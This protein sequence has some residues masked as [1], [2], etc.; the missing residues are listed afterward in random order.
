MDF[1]A[2][3]IK[4]ALRTMEQLI[5]VSG[6][7]L[8]FEYLKYVDYKNSNE[9]PKNDIGW[10]DGDRTVRFGG[11]DRHFWL[12]FTIEPKAFEEDREL[13]LSVTTGREGGWDLQNPQGLVYLNGEAY[14]ALDTN[15][16]W[17]SL[18]SEKKY[19]VYIYFYTGMNDADFAIYPRICLMDTQLFEL[20][21]DIKTAYESMHRQGGNRKIEDTLNKALMLLDFRNPYS[22]DFY[23]SIC[24]TREYLESEL[25]CG[26]DPNAPTVACIGHTHIDIAWLWTIRQTREKAERSFL[27]VEELMKK[28]PEYRFMSSQPQLYSYVKETNPRL[29]SEIKRY[30]KER[31]WEAEGAMWLE[32]DTNLTGGESLIRQ[33]IFGKNFMKEEFGTD[34]RVL[35]LPDVFGYSA[36]LPQI[37]KKCGIDCFF[38]T[39]IYWNETNSMPH[40]TFMW[41]GLDGSAVL[42]HFAKEY[43]KQLTPDEVYNTWEIYKDKS[44]SDEVLLTFGF[45]DGGGGTTPEMLEYYRRL[46][47]GIPGMPRVEMKFAGEFFDSLKEKFEKNTKEL[48]FMP[49]WKGELYLEMHRGTYTTMS[50]NKKCNRKSEFLS[51][52][53]ESLSITDMLLLGNAVERERIEKNIRIML[54]NQFHDIIPGS[55]IEEVYHDSERD[56]DKII[57][58]WERMK[59]EKLLKLSENTSAKSGIFVYNATP[60]EQSGFVRAEENDYYAEKIPPHGYRVIEDKPILCDVTAGKYLLENELIKV[61]FDEKYNIISVFDKEIKRELIPKGETANRLEVYED[62]PRDYDAWEITDYYK[63]KRWLADDVESAEILK[64]G[65]KVTRRYNKSRICQTILLRPGSKRIDFVTEV[66]W[67]EKHEMLK[68]AFP[69]DIHTRNVVYD[70]QFGNIERPTYQN[71]SWEAAKFEVCG[72]KWADMSEC[73]YGASL[74]NDC[75]YGYSAFENCL[76]LTLLRAPE[77]P[78]PNAD[79]GKHSFTYSLYPHI[80][81]F[82]EG[83]TI[84]EAYLLNEPLTAIKLCGAGGALPDEYSLVSCDCENITVET[85]KPAENDDSVVVRLFD[86]F[87]KKSIPMLTLGFDFDEVYI[88]DML[89]NEEQ[90]LEHDGRNVSVPVGNYEIVTLKFKRR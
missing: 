79:M 42:T 40:D 68:A 47:K 66:D 84:P 27:T 11:R 12:R 82:R 88:C 35:W 2:E 37:M 55:A 61:S 18:E 34:N 56:Y 44:L 9:L 8:D 74:M 13:I 1:I 53:V 38:T 49:K 24:K 87:N 26:D 71:T 69:L 80:G 32:A 48:K 4:A 76:S 83:R 51:A 60:Y 7:D 78:N 81:D 16:T 23:K 89:E 39:K 36:A 43:N 33:I 77:Y 22:E 45:G 3:K 65:I 72:H 54:L 58:D 5:E 14:R 90:K 30:I 75:K 28:Y 6:T 59:N 31:R 70:I 20:Y 17:I 73:G 19:E 67:H 29:Y 15:H 52:C 86:C 46:K 64:N 21:F 10:N 63:Q 50:K 41:E 25:Y 57:S 85:I 62:Y